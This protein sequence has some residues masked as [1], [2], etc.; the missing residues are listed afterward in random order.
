MGEA[1]LKREP[2]KIP[3]RDDVWWYEENGGIYVV[4]ERFGHE[5][6]TGIKISWTALRNALARK[7]Q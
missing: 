6:T 7:D 5:D 1:N 4:V 3:K 2:H